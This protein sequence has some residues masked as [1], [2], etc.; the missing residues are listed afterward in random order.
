MLFLV[1]SNKI[2][3]PSACPR[4]WKRIFNVMSILARGRGKKILPEPL[5]THIHALL[6]L[7]SLSWL[8]LRLSV[9][10]SFS[11]LVSGSS[12]FMRQ[13]VRSPTRNVRFVC[14]HKI[15]QSHKKDW[16][17]SLSPAAGPPQHTRTWLSLSAGLLSLLS[18]RVKASLQSPNSVSLSLFPSLPPLSFPKVVVETPLGVV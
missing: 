6:N 17:T 3:H 15:R 2:V 1:L 10:T 7:S 8:A 16:Q 12:L 5:G 4:E 11:L 13:T 14:S 18:P 9:Q